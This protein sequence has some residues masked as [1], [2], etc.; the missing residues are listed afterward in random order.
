MRQNGQYKKILL[1]T[2]IIILLGAFPA[3]S[4]DPPPKKECKSSF[5]DIVNDICWDCMYP[6]RVGGKVIL[7]ADNMPDNVQEITSNP[8]DYTPGEYICD[9]EGQNDEIFFGIYVSFWEP[10]RVMEIT[11][12][13]GC[14]SFMFGMDMREALGATYGVKGP[15]PVTP[16]EKSFQHVHY[17]HAP[18]MEM[19]DIFGL[20]DFCKEW[21]MSGLDI[22]YMTELSPLWKDDE[23]NL[24]VRAES[25]V[26]A[27][28]VAQTLC[29]VDCLAASASYPINAMFWCQGCWGSIYP[30]SGHLGHVIGSPITVSSNLMVR[31]L[32]EMARFPA[33]PAVE[34][35]TSSSFAK[36][37]GVIR[38]V[39]K[40]SQYRINTLSPI[41]EA[42]SYH[43]L[44]ASSFLWGEHRTIPATGEDH[45]FVVWRKRNC[46]LKLV[47][48]EQ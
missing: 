21:G 38:P 45:S 30:M 2:A 8:D 29:T 33:P 31:L 39:L 18:I 35:D 46:C 15:A 42:K 25:A 36:C 22:A 24:L 19:L 47:D 27:N 9:C 32:A 26:F 28:P 41:P 44:G 14:F 7:K 16:L 20:A 17:Y 3:R 1:L 34:Y 5:P 10:A 12:E 4:D 23:L 37:G 11:P 48:A 6:I 40:K 43:S 13:P